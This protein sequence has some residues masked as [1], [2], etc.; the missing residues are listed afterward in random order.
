VVDLLQALV[1]HYA[2]RPNLLPDVAGIDAGSDAALHAAVA[3]VGG[4]TDRFA[5][6]QAVTLLGW[7]D[8]RLPQGIGT[9]A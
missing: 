1:E 2:D 5:C 9:S 6:R 7:S 4:M 3:Y 8:R